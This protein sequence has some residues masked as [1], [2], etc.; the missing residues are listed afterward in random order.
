[1]QTS[2]YNFK[3]TLTSKP[4]LLTQEQ[5]NK[6][7]LKDNTDY[8]VSIFKYSE[9]QK[10]R[11]EETGSV[12]GITDVTTSNL[13]WDFD[14]KANP[15]LARQDAVTLATRLVSAYGVDPDI[16]QC[17]YSGYKGFHLTL[18]IDKEISPDAFKKATGEL[19]KDLKTYDLSVNDPA[20]I[21]RVYN[22]KNP[23]TGL[24][25]IPLKIYEV[26]EMN[27]EQI[28]ELAI[29]TQPTDFVST[30]VTNLPDALFAVKPKKKV[31]TLTKLSNPEDYKNPP[32]G[33]KEYKWAIAQGHF[34]SGERHMALMVLAATCR[35]LGYDS[36]QTYYLC[37]SALKKQARRTGTEEFSKEELW[38]DIIDESVF[39]D[40]WEGGAYSP[41]THP[42]LKEYCKRMGFDTKSDKKPP[43]VMKLDNLINQ[44]IDYSTN[45]ETNLIP[46][47]ITEL[48]QNLIL[49]TSTLN[50]LLGQPGSGKTTVA[51]EILKNASLANIP[52]MFFSLD[53]GP[54]LVFSKLVQ[55]ESGLGFKC[56]LEI[57]REQKEKR[58]EISAIIKT[59]YKNVGFNFRCGLTVADMKGAI[60]EQQ[61]ATG[62]KPKL[63][64][65]DYLENIAG[66]YSDP[67]ANAGMITNQLKDMATEMEVCIL[68]LLQ[69]QKHSTPDISDPLLSMKQ[70]KGSSAIEQN[71]S[72]VITL[73]REGYNPDHVADD[74]YISFALVKNRFGS[75]WKGDFHWSP[76]KGEITSLSEEQRDDL[77][78]FKKR[79]RDSKLADIKEKSDWT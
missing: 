49:S 14:D 78:E 71:C 46:T 52:S 79:K 57:Y 7:K 43:P 25:K 18:P 21:L 56:S 27:M 55:K 23:K 35:S 51:V 63:I 69:T 66:P 12:A 4:K 73:W 44:F 37:K 74:K 11:I 76:I 1:M 10:K 40:R 77:A 72:V 20:R 36:E 6:V 31:G 17:A 30:T 62:I 28:K 47:G 34:E 16:I 5:I 32:K 64:V 15:D 38:T 65:V 2:Y 58:N 53:M 48:D 9:A 22:T 24:Y 59:K 19:A 54:P 60:L 70:I 68:L 33:W 3:E 39:S 45:F 29:S 61:E 13:V 41:D 8:Y 26:D 50:G 42:W 75:L 67:T